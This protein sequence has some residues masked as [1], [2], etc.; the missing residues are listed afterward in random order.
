MATIGDLEPLIKL[1]PCSGA[2]ELQAISALYSF[3]FFFGAGERTHG[4]LN[5]RTAHC[6]LCSILISLLLL[7]HLIPLILYYVSSLHGKAE[8]N[9]MDSVLSFHSADPR[10]NSDS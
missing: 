9:F 3:F 2:L 10:G 1:P 4:F 8:D 7:K 6:Q 5:A